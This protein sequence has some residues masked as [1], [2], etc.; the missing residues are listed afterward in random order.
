[1]SL[2]EG[3][4]RRL[5][6]KSDYYGG[7]SEIVNFRLKS[8]CF[9]CGVVVVSFQSSGAGESTICTF[10]EVKQVGFWKK[11]KSAI[12]GCHAGESSIFHDFE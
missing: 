1:M 11:W 9:F 12:W 2:L 5:A 4:W 7:K 10:M 6:K 3:V 8:K